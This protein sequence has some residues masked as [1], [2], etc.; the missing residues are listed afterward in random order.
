MRFTASAGVAFGVTFG[1]GAGVAFGVAFGVGAG[2]AF[3]VGAGV[4][5]GVGAGVAFG[6][7]AGVA[8]CV[9]AGVDSVFSQDDDE[10]DT[11]FFNITVS[12]S[13]LIAG[14]SGSQS[15]ENKQSVPV[16]F[17]ESCHFDNEEVGPP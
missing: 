10:T 8:F 16:G 14:L 6:V 13:F 7:G 11:L 5:F 9:G 3:G 4:A 15:L 2:V 17:H 1:V 12:F